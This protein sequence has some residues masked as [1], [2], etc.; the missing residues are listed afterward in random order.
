VTWPAYLQRS[1]SNEELSMSFIDVLFKPNG[2]IGSGQF[3]AGW[4]A[5]VAANVIS[6]FIPILNILLYFGLIYV[7]VCVYGKRLH[8]M[9]RSAWL[10]AIPW[11]IGLVLGIVGLFLS[12]PGIMELSQ[13]DQ[14]ALENPV[15]AMSAMGP[16]LAFVG[17]GMCLW[18]ALTVWV[19][20][21]KTDPNDNQYGPG[22]N[23][24]QDVFV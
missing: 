1:P 19:G 18:L 20:T 17:I 21:G 24:S 6:N 22:P 16:Y 4:G 13:G 11:G 3:W 7:G 2:R 5:L 23:G 12:A 9:G 10:V 14:Q 15:V 8:D